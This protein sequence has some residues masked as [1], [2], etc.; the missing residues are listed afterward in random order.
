MVGG[1]SAG[2][3]VFGR[4]RIDRHSR[5]S[6]EYSHTAG[7]SAAYFNDVAVAAG[8]VSVLCPSCSVARSH[9][10]IRRHPFT[11]SRRLLCPRRLRDGH[12]PHAPDRNARRLRQSAVARFHGVPELEGTALVLVRLRHVPVCRRHGAADPRTVRAGV[13]LVRLPL[14]RDRRVPFDHHPDDDLRTLALVLSQRHGIRRQQR[15]HRFQ[16][17]PW[18]FGSITADAGDLVRAFRAGVNARI[19][20][21]PLCRRVQGR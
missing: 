11:W 6:T 19:Y 20:P 8:Q 15:P 18:L 3:G 13:W 9:L 2:S 12:V 21:R 5:A 16:R 14:A 7:L 1:R 4:A 10:G 17:H